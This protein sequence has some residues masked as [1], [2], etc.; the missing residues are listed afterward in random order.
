[1]QRKLKFQSRI[2]KKVGYKYLLRLPE[3][4]KATDRKRW[5]L[6]LFLHGAG[7]RGTDLKLV[8]K[9]GPPKVVTQKKEFPFIIVSPQCPLE[10]IWDDEALLA[11][12][13]HII[14]RF[15]IDIRRVCLTGLSMGG[16]GTWSLGLKYPER[17]AAIAPICGGGSGADVLLA[18]SVKGRALRSLAV[19]AFHGARDAVVPVIESKIIVAAL[20]KAGCRKVALTVYP[21]AE[22]DS[23]TRTY[24]RH[25]LY[26]WLLRQRRK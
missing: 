26:K 7:E 23:Y 15:R 8:T 1:L 3:D 10:Q 20:R 12:L 5:P 2:S 4:Y 11:L 19:W 24:N 21:D 18:G 16:Y 25:E 14:D 13:D 22:H 17:F 6:L 9:H